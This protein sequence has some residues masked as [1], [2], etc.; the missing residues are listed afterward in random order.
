LVAAHANNRKWI[1][2]T[3]SAETFKL[4]LKRLESQFGIEPE[5][6]FNAGDQRF[7]EKNYPAKYRFYRQL[8]SIFGPSKDKTRFVLDQPVK[9]KE[10]RIYEF[11]E[12]K[13][14]NAIDAIKNTA[15]EYAVAFLNSG[16]PVGHRSWGISASIRVVKGVQLNYEEQDKLER[17]VTEKLFN[18]QPGLDPGVIEI[19]LHPVYEIESIP[20]RY[21]VELVVYP[22][23]HIPRGPYY[24]G[25]GEV[26]VK[27][28]AGKKKLQG[29]ELTD[30]II[31]HLL[32]E[33]PNDRSI[34]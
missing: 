16:V 13:G 8:I 19:N 24:T 33:S 12:I 29:Q 3:P 10:G 4:T 20:D 5:K 21:V 22:G 15:D 17:Q 31:R 30:W 2:C 11:K 34:E 9:M 18:I 32:N 27:T 28:D 26:F 23:T 25:G 7:L 6:D 14:K 1:G